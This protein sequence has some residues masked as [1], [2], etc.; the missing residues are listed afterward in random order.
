VRWF[1]EDRLTLSADGKVGLKQAR[2]ASGAL[3][4]PPPDA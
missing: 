1:C 2:V 3:L 4:V